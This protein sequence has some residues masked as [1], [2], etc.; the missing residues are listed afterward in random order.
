MAAE[1]YLRDNL[2]QWRK[3]KEFY[4]HDGNDWRNIQE[5]YYYDGASWRKV[6][7]YTAPSSLLSNPTGP[8]RPDVV[9]SSGTYVPTYPRN[10]NN[11]KDATNAVVDIAT[12]G[13]GELP[14]KLA[15]RLSGRGHPARIVIQL[16]L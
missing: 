1:V 16:F 3:A 8:V 15:I 7:Q 9:G 14:V 11:S 4:F 12:F 6:F 2:A 5:A 13:I 10:P